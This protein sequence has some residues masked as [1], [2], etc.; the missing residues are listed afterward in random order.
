VENARPGPELGLRLG[1][2]ALPHQLDI[3]SLAA[4]HAPNFGEALRKLARYKR[5]A[6]PEEV[7]LEIADREAKLR[8]HWLLAADQHPPTLLVDATFAS[9]LALGRRGMGKAVRVR[10]LELTRRSTH[11]AVLTRHF[12][13][14]I[15]FDAPIDLL[16][17]DE[18]ALAEPFMTHNEDLLAVMLPGLENALDELGAVPSLVDDVRTVIR[19]CMD[20]QRPSI[21]RIAGEMGMSSRTLQRHLGVAGASYQA[22]LDEVRRQSARRLVAN[23]DLDAGDVAFLLGFEELN[24]FTRAFHTWEGT[25]PSRWRGSDGHQLWSRARR[26]GSEGSRRRVATS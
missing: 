10:R 6:C 20:G 18:S 5:L 4:L 3:A 12:E 9:V 16:V 14:E 19:R 8:F 13:C 23:T 22:L 2:E 24:S 21:E 15:W 1:S 25:T 11:E 7:E 26:A 17:L